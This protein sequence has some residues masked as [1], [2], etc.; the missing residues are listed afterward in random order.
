MGKIVKI[1]SD[2]DVRVD[3]G[4]C[5]FNL[6]PG[7]CTPEPGDREDFWRDEET[8]NEPQASSLDDSD[9]DSSGIDAADASSYKSNW[10]SLILYCNN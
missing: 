1:D 10:H 4:D 7:C 2:G 8:Q 9:D 3:F 5:R 6:S